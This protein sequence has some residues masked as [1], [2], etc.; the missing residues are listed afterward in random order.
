MESIGE[1]IRE[2]RKTLKLNQTDFAKRI[3][4]ETAG[5]VSKL[6]VGENNPSEQTIKMICREFGV[7]YGWLKYGHDPMMEPKESIDLGRLERIMDGDNEYVKSVFRELMDMPEEWWEQ[8][9]A[10]LDRIA[11]QKKGR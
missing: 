5:G 10:M 3:G 1:R 7:N 4:F 8:A 6:E 9:I 11:A 2:L